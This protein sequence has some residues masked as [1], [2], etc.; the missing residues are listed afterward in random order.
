M[1]NNNIKGYKVN[2]K[3]GSYVDMS[4][5]KETLRVLDEILANQNTKW[6]NIVT[7]E[8]DYGLINITNISTIFPIFEDAKSSQPSK[9]LEALSIDNVINW[10]AFDFDK[11]ETRPPKSGKY[12]IYKKDGKIHWETWNGSSWAYNHKVIKYWAIIKPPCL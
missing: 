10:V 8:S 9:K 4:N 7:P 6:I 11:L 12:L 5:D 2:F 3:N 1:K